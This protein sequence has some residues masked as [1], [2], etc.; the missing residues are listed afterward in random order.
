[1]IDITFISQSW[2]ISTTYLLYIKVMVIRLCEAGEAHSTVNASRLAGF[3][4]WNA[5][6]YIAD[7]ESNGKKREEPIC[8]VQ[9]QLSI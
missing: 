8:P 4:Q 2:Y 6:A 1:M 9:L 5:G 7:T 3:S